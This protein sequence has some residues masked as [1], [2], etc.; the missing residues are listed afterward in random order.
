[1]GGTMRWILFCGLCF[2]SISSLADDAINAI[3]MLDSFN[4]FDCH[5][6][7]VELSVSQNSSVGVLG[8]F[9][10]D[11]DRSTY[12]ETN[13]NVTN[14]FSRILIPWRYAKGGVFKTGPFMQ[15]LIGMEKSEFRSTLG[16]RADVTFVDFAFHYGYQWFWDNGFNVSVMGGVGLLVKTSD[17]KDI[18]Q[19]ES[20][21][22]RDFLDKNTK[23]N[24][25]PGA[26]VVMGWR[27]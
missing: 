2:Q 10:C 17:E 13:D 4:S 24:I 8:I 12:G 16:S 18:V 9:D 6:P 23:T 19:N 26:G 1:M 3:L 11:T 22:V 20:N 21:D 27:F 5:H 25:H 7:G 15:A 14:T